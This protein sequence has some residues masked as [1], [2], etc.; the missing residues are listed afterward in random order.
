MEEFS[1][2]SEVPML[3]GTHA[4]DS[5]E[6]ELMEDSGVVPEVYSEHDNVSGHEAPTKA[7]TSAVVVTSVSGE[8][9]DDINKFRSRSLFSLCHMKCSVDLV[10]SFCNSID[11]LSLFFFF[12]L[13]LPFCRY[14]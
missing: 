2:S 7:G 4:Q 5:I 6:S 13:S 3:E 14:G 11:F 12:F 1:T 9:L 8:H 10:E